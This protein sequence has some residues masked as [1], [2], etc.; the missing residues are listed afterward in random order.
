MGNYFGGIE[1]GGTKFVCAVGSG[2]DEIIAEARFQTTT[3]ME[4]I[5]KV[6]TFFKSYM[7]DLGISAI[8]IGSFGP[9]DLQPSSTTYGSITKTTKPG[10]SN[11]DIAGELKKALGLPVAIDTD[12][13]AAAFGERCWGAAKGLSDFIYL[14]IGTGVGGGAMSNGKLVH[15]LVHPEMGHIPLPHDLSLDPFPGVCP[16][17]ND[18]FEGLASGPA[19]NRRWDAPGEKLAPDHPAWALEAHYIANIKSGA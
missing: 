19:V 11:T 17:H 10:W 1:A 18:C 12:V 5:Q 2:P 16:F 15:G 9:L 13:N 7:E 8:G 4:T 6:V 3:P 14:T